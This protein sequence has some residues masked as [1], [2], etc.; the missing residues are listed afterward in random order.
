MKMNKR[1]I[2]LLVALL[3]AALALGG[4]WLATRGEKQTPA[5]APAAPAEPTPAEPTPAEPAPA[6]PAPAE[7]APAEQAPTEPAPAE[8][9]EP[10]PA[11][12]TP[13]SV[14][15]QVQLVYDDVDKTLEVTT[16]E[17]TLAGA[18]QAAELITESSDSAFG[19]YITGIDG[20]TADSMAQEWWCITKDGEMTETGADGVM[21]AEGDHYELTL[22]V[23][24][25]F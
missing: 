13:E 22:K 18:L 16:H 21:I 19:I 10:A 5:P 15:I 12:E 1:T 11:P 23:G 20:R 7:P 3:V 9:P 6:E 24:Y 25:D 14:T 4:I 8:T 2:A 17:E